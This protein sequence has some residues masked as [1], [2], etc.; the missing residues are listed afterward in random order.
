[1]TTTAS[2]AVRAK[3]PRSPREFR[4]NL[5]FL[6]FV[7]PNLAL[8]SLFLFWPLLYNVYLSFV[9]WDFLSPIKTWV[10]L[11]N[12]QAVFADPVF[13]RVLLNTF[14]FTI[15]SVAVTLTLG[16]ALALLLNQKLRFRNSARAVLFTP[17]VLSGA[18]IAVVWTYMFDPRFGVLQVVLGWVGLRSPDWLTSPQWAMP[19]III[20]Y[21]WKNLGYAVVIYLAGLQAIDRSLYEAATVD[22]AGPWARFRNV[23]LPGLSPILFFLVVTSILACFQSFDVVRVMT[24]GGPINATNTLI[25]YLY[26][27]GFVS[28]NAGYSG[29]AAVSMFV[30]LAVLTFI[31]LRYTERSV[32]Y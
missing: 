4:E 2:P 6:L 32:T 10:G 29:V 27:T 9:S 18:A 11:A 12:Y 19:A 8:I 21:I 1:M 28:Y 23:T 15:G 17:T 20:V 13:H 5:L 22:G 31:Q 24:A 26:E 7:G 25:Y 16:L 30:I 14:V 3:A